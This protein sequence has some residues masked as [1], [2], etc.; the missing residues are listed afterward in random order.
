[1]KAAGAHRRT[2]RPMRPIVTFLLAIA[3][4]GAGS[5]SAQWQWL[6]KS[7]H[8]VYSDQPPPSDIPPR[9]ILKQP[10]RTSSAAV[11][12]AAP[13]APVPAVGA[14]AA[15]AAQGP[16]LSQDDRELQARKAKAEA[17]A[18]ARVKAD[19]QAK[20]QVKAAN[21]EK[22]RKNQ[23]LMDSGVRVSITNA[24]GEREVLDDTARAAEQ[25]K[26]R[27]VIEQNCN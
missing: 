6:D 4:L 12:A 3:C 25:K 19:E 14:S 26:I 16:A 2:L 21:C 9:N 8:K 23:A 22:A 27:T 1:M 7:G 5:A 10:G 18:V 15:P 11:A 13:P 24:K 17:D 20:D